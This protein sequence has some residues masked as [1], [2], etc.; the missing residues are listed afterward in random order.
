MKYKLRELFAA[1]AAFLTLASCGAEIKA[2]AHNV[3][4]RPLTPGEIEM[5]SEIFGN[6]I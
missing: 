4:R 3:D 6:Q 1:S 2:D 5:A